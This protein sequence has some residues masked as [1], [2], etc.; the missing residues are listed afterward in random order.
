VLILAFFIF[1]TDVM[2]NKSKN[3]SAT[4]GRSKKPVASILVVVA[5]SLAT[6]YFFHLESMPLTPVD[7]TF[8]VGVWVV[9]V[10]IAKWLWG[11]FHR[12]SKPG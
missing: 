3:D 1:C 7:T 2:E 12:N 8:V 4:K 10:L 6:W 11:R 9:V 5:L